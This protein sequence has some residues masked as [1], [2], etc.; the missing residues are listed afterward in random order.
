MIKKK[1]LE[2]EKKKKVCSI[3]GKEYFLCSNI[4]ATSEIQALFI[5]LI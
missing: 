4:V 1:R 5:Y 3:N 2:N